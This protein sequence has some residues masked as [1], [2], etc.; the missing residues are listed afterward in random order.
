MKLGYASSHTYAIDAVAPNAKVID[1]GAGPFGVGHELKN[2]NCSVVTVDQFDIPDKYK[3]PTYPK[4]LLIESVGDLLPGEIVHRKKMGF[5]FPWSVWLKN[6]LRSFC[7]EKMHAL[8]KRNF[9]DGKILLQ[10]W[11]GYLKGNPAIRWPDM[12]ICVV[13]ENWIEQNGINE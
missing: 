13:L 5:V 8:A 10:R 3:F 7:D 9:I 4:K 2:K 6:E 1:V 11:N 12:W